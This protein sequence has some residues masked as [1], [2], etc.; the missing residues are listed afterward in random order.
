MITF[1]PSTLQYWASQKPAFVPNSEIIIDSIN[2][3]EVTIIRGLSYI[4]INNISSGRFYVL[5]KYK[6]GC[7]APLLFQNDLPEHLPLFNYH[8]VHIM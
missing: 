7:N 2:K 5:A 3:E 1:K 4:D 8:I 6:I